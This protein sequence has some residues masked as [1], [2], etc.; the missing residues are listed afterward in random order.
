MQYRGLFIGLTTIDIQYFVDSF[1]EQNVKIKTTP[2][3]IL[4][5][6]PAANAALAFAKLNKSA[7]L[8]SAVGRNSFSEF[9]VDDFKKNNISFID[10]IEDNKT[11]PVIASVITCKNGNRNIFTHNP[12]TITPKISAKELLEK[13][14]PEILLLDGFY[15]EFGVECTQ[16]AKQKNIPV[17]LD[18][19]SWKP[20]YE[21]LL[22]YADVVIC[23]NDFYPP[24]CINSKQVFQYLKKK[25]IGKI[26]ISNG[27]EDIV[28]LNNKSGKIT[29]DKTEVI[30]TL[31]AGD[32]LHGSFCYYYCK[33]RH[34]KKALKLASEVASFSCKYKGT[35]SWLNYFPE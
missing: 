34:F 4:V 3:D 25:K 33:Y 31:G 22:N 8:V 21:I 32:I 13:L 5:G 35:R 12:E 10:I 11:N 29:I 20:Q 7:N 30:D 9:I 23:S 26:A 28:F 17:V 15:P 2:P 16:I 6:G 1:P 27:E 19:G 14:Q 24:N 18:C